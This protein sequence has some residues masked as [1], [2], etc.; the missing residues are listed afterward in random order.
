MAQDYLVGATSFFQEI[1]EFGHPV[2][3]ALVVNGLG[4]LDNARGQPRGVNGER[5]VAVAE[6][7]SD[8]LCLG[9]KFVNLGA[10]QGIVG[11]LS[12]GTTSSVT[13]SNGRVG[14]GGVPCGPT[15]RSLT[16]KA[17]GTQLL[18][19]GKPIG[20]TLGYI[21][22]RT[23]GGVYPIPH[24]PRTSDGKQSEFSVARSPATFKE[25]KHGMRL[26]SKF[27]F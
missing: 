27:P 21:D 10:D 5:R 4:Q 2:E 24:A 11:S 9:K 1:G 12:L 26:T 8:Q 18:R 7:I 13:G 19:T 17:S 22:R 25:L 14:G 15:S 20:K 3:S 23:T 16:G 6:D